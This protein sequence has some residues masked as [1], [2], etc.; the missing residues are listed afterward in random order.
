MIQCT[1]NAK[2]EAKTWVKID[3]EDW[4]GFIIF[5]NDLDGNLNVLQMS[6]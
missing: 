4:N 1:I 2:I 3:F 5:I 6:G